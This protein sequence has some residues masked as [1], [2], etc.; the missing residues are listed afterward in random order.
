MTNLIEG[1]NILKFRQYALLA[2]LN[3]EIL[4]MK[5]SRGPSAYFIIKQ[6]FGLKGNKQKVYNQFKKIL[7]YN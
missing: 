1:N 3:L 2:A 7:E 5:K 4:G 6:E